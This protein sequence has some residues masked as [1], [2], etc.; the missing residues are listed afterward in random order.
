ML[1]QVVMWVVRISSKVRAYGGSESVPSTNW[2]VPSS[3]STM[4]PSFNWENQE[5]QWSSAPISEWATITS[6]GMKEVRP[7]SIA[8]RP[9]QQVI[10]N[11]STSTV[12]F[13]VFA[14]VLESWL[15]N[16]SC[17]QRLLSLVCMHDVLQEVGYAMLFK[18]ESDEARIIWAGLGMHDIN[19]R[20]TMA[21]H[22]WVL[23]LSLFKRW[24]A[25][26]KAFGNSSWF[27]QLQTRVASLYDK[28]RQGTVESLSSQQLEVVRS[29]M[30]ISS[31][32]CLPL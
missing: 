18:F 8:W 11:L 22:E 16:S 4:V 23:R 27:G 14:E 19:V 5:R 6:L 2:A 15:C 7:G 21:G 24:S 13:R 26:S 20:P 31:E 25:V 3:M 9:L 30:R 17:I 1:H 32:S 28:H 10:T 29:V 12:S